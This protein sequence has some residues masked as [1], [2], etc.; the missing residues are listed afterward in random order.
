MPCCCRV[1]WEHE[2]LVCSMKFMKPE[3]LLFLSLLFKSCSSNVNRVH[4]KVQFSYTSPFL[5]WSIGVSSTQ[6]RGVHTVGFGHSSHLESSIH[7]RGMPRL[8]EHWPQVDLSSYMCL[9][10]RL[11]RF[12]GWDYVVWLL[13][14][15][16]GTVTPNLW[17]LPHPIRWAQHA[18]S[19]S[20]RVLLPVQT[21]EGN[22]MHEKVLYLFMV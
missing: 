5:S 13:W 6:R 20:A 4:F 17:L 1:Q 10:K 8:W 7:A 18:I 9:N 21:T 14:Q 2:H 22:I 19:C 16:R 3:T 11:C 12:R 15:V